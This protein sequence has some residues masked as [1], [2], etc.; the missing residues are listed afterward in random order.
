MTCKQQTSVEYSSHRL[1]LDQHATRG[2]RFPAKRTITNIPLAC[3]RRLHK[4]SCRKNKQNSQIFQ[5]NP[6]NLRNDTSSGYWK[7]TEHSKPH[8]I[9]VSC[10]SFAGKFS[11]IRFVC[12]RECNPMTKPRLSHYHGPKIVALPLMAWSS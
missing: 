1:G 7:H 9:G 6:S 2:R 11:S 12:N 3:D 5:E 10:H 4:K 8:L